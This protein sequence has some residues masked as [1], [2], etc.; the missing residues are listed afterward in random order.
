[1]R[2]LIRCVKIPTLAHGAEDFSSL[3]K[4]VLL[5]VKLKKTRYFSEF[6]MFRESLVFQLFLRY[7]KSL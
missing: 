4:P 5:L 6:S 2:I 7:Y 1:M 3:C